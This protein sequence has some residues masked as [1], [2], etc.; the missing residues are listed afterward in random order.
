[1]ASK[2]KLKLFRGGE[3]VEE[4]PS[5]DEAECL[6]EPVFESQSFLGTLN[7]VKV[8]YSKRKT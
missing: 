6:T 2:F 7:D 8:Q 1:M 4:M 5:I 3:D